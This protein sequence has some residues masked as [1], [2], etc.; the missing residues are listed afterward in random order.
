MLWP[1]L[2]IFFHGGW[3][4]ILK[5]ILI[6]DDSMLLRRLV[7]KVL[8][9]MGYMD[10]VEVENGLEALNELKKAPFD[11]VICD[12]NMPHMRGDELFVQ[13]KEDERLKDIS[14]IMLTANRDEDG[15]REQVGDQTIKIILKPIKPETLKEKMQ[16]I[17]EVV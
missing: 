6:V 1:F 10:V 9:S 12:Y 5:K 14:F 3:W 7:K 17:F 11:L 13:M 2:L 16:E 4:D 15:L 8:N